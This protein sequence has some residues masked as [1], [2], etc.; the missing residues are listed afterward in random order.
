MEFTQEFINFA[1]Y[2]HGVNKV[3]NKLNFKFKGC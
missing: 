3:L 2:K 1:R